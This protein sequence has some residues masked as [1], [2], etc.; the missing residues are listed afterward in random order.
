MKYFKRQVVVPERDKEL[1]ESSKRVAKEWENLR[2]AM[3][4]LK[5]SLLKDTLERKSNG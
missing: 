1:E 3:E 2:S 4:D 5:E